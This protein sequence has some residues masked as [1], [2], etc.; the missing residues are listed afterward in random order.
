MTDSYRVDETYIKVRRKWAYLYRAVDSAG[1][2]IDFMLTA[3]R[4]SSAAKRFFRKALKA[5]PH[6]LPRVI[7]IDKNPAYPPAVDE[8]KAE[9][10]LARDCEL[11]RGKYLNNRVEMV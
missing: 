9:G 6:R 8:L 4:D 1:Q 2:T 7:T 11:R 5:P 10:I 3:E